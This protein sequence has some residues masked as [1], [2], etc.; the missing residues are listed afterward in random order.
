MNLETRIRATQ[1]GPTSLT[2]APGTSGW[3]IR[4]T[5]CSHGVC[6]MGFRVGNE[7]RKNVT[8]APAPQRKLRLKVSLPPHQAGGNFRS[9]Q[10]GRA[11]LGGGGVPELALQPRGPRS[12]KNA[13]NPGSSVSGRGGNEDTKEFSPNFTLAAL[14]SHLPEPLSK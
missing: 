7:C 3:R 8:S 11:G 5:L 13:A 2:I 1:K 9:S 10:A 6:L 12:L 4:T 14:P